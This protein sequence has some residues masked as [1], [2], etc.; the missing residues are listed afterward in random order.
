[1]SQEKSIDDKIVELIKSKRPIVVVTHPRSGTHLTID[2]MRHH[3]QGCGGWKLP[4]EANNLVYLSLDGITLPDPQLDKKYAVKVL[5]RAKTPIIKTHSFN[6]EFDDVGFFGQSGRYIAPVIA[7]ALRKHARFIYVIRDC[8]NVMTSFHHWMKGFNVAAQNSTFEE[9]LVAEPRPN[10]NRIQQWV[11]HVANWQ[12]FEDI[13]TIRFEDL[14]SDCREVA[15]KVSAYT[16]IP[17]RTKLLL[18]DKTSFFKS[19]MNR[20][21]STRPGST[22]IL[23]PKKLKPGKWE[24]QITPE[25]SSKLLADAAA[26][27]DQFGYTH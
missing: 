24:K 4:L 3:F 21:F 25:Q 13:L 17:F 16:G 20:L 7:D 18:P 19:R 11:Q 1:M 10:A 5:K 15:G 6:P 23:G 14:V 26:T 22:A 27:M 9:F 8:R 12:A 2:F